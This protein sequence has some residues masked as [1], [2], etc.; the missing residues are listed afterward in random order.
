MIY[1]IIIIYNVI[2]GKAQKRKEIKEAGDGAFNPAAA[3]TA[4]AVPTAAA[5][6]P[7]L[8]YYV[9]S[10]GSLIQVW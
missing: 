1:Y 8:S 10:L 7:V 4:A 6:A 3:P 5:A 2:F 9:S